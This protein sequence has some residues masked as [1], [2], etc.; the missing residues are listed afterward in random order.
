MPDDGCGILVSVYDVN[1][2]VS[3][4]VPVDVIVVAAADLTPEHSTQAYRLQRNEST[5]QITGKYSYRNQ[6]SVC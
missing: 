3:D 4:G 2:E 1:I 6:I 5:I